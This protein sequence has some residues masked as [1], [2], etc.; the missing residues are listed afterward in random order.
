[1]QE[2]CLPIK[3]PEDHV[4]N[5]S[6]QGNSILS[7]TPNKTG[8]LQQAYHWF[9]TWDAISTTEYHTSPDLVYYKQSLPF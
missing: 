6:S 3:D 9:H 4:A 7:I 1:M 2:P 5:L 8:T